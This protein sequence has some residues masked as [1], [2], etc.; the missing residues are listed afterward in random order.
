[1]IWSMCWVI[2]LCIYLKKKK[3]F[4]AAPAASAR[5]RETPVIIVNMRARQMCTPLPLS[6]LHEQSLDVCVCVFVCVHIPTL[7]DLQ[8]HECVANPWWDICSSKP[9]FCVLQALNSGGL[10]PFVML[11]PP[12]SDLITVSLLATQLGAGVTG[13]LWDAYWDCV[14]RA[15][16]SPEVEGEKGLPLWWCAHLCQHKCQV[17]PRM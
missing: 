16:T 2:Y 14:W 11:S 12:A 17:S 4:L 15:G 10:A 13:P 6:L 9:D 7:S 3:K 1:M 8:R 5:W